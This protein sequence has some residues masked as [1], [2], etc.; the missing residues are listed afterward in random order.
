[1]RCSKSARTPQSD[2]NT[3][4][5]ATTQRFR[6]TFREAD[7]IKLALAHHLGERAHGVFHRDLGVDARGLEE[8]DLLRTA[9][10]GDA[11]VYA[12][13]EIFS[14]ADGTGSAMLDAGQTA[15]VPTGSSIRAGEPSLPRSIRV[16]GWARW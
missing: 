16:S 13:P 14:P 7:V 6:T 8:V 5:V 3:Y 4:G 10:R 15:D 1:M 12:L 11:L 9:Q 2:L